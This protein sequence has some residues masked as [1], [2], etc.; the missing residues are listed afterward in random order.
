MKM[1]NFVGICAVIAAVAIA[2][3]TLMAKAPET[4]IDRIRKALLKLP[5]YSVFDFLAFSYDKGSVTLQGFAYRPTLKSDAERALKRVAGVD[6]I[7]DQVVALPVSPNDDE[8]RWKV[9]W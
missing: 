9:Y 5:Y 6:T 1:R 4:P 7:N 2:S 8:I 3:P